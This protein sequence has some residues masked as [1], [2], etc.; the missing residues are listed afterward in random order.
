MVV[1]LKKETG[2]GVLEGFVLFCLKP[3]CEK[4]SMRTMGRS[5]VKRNC[6]FTFEIGK[7]YHIFLLEAK[8]FLPEVDSKGKTISGRAS[9]WLVLKPMSLPFFL[10]P[11]RGFFSHL[12]I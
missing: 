6:L 1:A 11:R 5:R 9:S 10:L 12:N 3:G 7:T 2:G 4:D 8:A